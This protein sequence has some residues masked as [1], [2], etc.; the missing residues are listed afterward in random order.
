MSEKA[1]QELERRVDVRRQVNRE[2]ASA[3]EFIGE[4]VSNL[5]RSGVFIR[6][7]DPLPVGTRVNLKF[8]V[9]SD[10]IE[11]IEG[12]GEVRRVIAP[13]GVEEPGMGVVF[14]ELSQA[15]REQIDRILARG[16]TR[17]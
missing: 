14:V 6:S 3:E 1:K 17:A 5:S 4:Y 13:G 8:T 15:S 10:D 7:T 2:F 12:V 9:V 16:H 11:I